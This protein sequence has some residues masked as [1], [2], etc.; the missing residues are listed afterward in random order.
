MSGKVKTF[1]VKICEEQIDDIG[2]KTFVNKIAEQV[3]R[4]VAFSS[5][6]T[7]VKSSDMDL[8]I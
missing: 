2:R 4:V 8:I 7:L 3:I 1:S 6:F 5:T